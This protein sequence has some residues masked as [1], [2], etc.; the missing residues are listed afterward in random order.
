CCYKFS[1]DAVQIENTRAL[2]SDTNHAVAQLNVGR[3]PAR[4]ATFEM[5]DVGTGGHGMF[6]LQFDGEV[7]E[8]CEP[9]IFSSSI[10]NSGNCDLAKTVVGGILKAAGD[11]A[12]GQLKSIINPPVTAP[13][14]SVLD[15]DVARLSVPPQEVPLTLTDITTV[16]LAA[17]TGPP[18][19]GGIFAA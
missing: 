6:N 16:A 19:V 9:A 18:F 4:S 11:F 13:V 12:S 10:V 2:H 3:S 1:V 15:D 7:V 8:L 17:T 14:L 5:G